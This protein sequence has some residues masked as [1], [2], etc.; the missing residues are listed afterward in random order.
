MG[1][2]GPRNH[3]ELVD[4]QLANSRQTGCRRGLHWKPQQ[5]RFD[6]TCGERNNSDRGS[7]I[8]PVILNDDDRPRFAAVGTSRRGGVDVPPPHVR[9]RRPSRRTPRRR[10]RD[11]LDPDRSRRRG[12]IDDVPRG[13]IRGRSRREP[14]SESAATLVDAVAGDTAAPGRELMPDG[15]VTCNAVERPRSRANPSREPTNS[16]GPK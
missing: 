3:R 2:A 16:I 1:E 6:L 9:C 11:R 15:H 12:P 7:R 10:R 4:H 14:R 13:R 5:R 8:R